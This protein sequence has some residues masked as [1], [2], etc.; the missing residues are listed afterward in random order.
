MGIS[1]EVSSLDK[2]FS[3]H[4][5]VCAERWL[6]TLT[7]IKRIETVIIVAAGAIITLMTSLLFK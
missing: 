7:R 6:E 4:E 2:R 5:Q 1:E 3:I